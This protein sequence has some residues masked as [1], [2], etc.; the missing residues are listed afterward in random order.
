MP[1]TKKN[2]R[3]YDPQ[4]WLR[5]AVSAQEARAEA[6][7]LTDDQQRD[8]GL[9]YWLCFDQMLHGGSEEAWHSLAS[10]LNIALV[11]VE[12]GFGAEY[13]SE[14]KDAQN[15]LMR[16]KSRQAR[17]GSW[18][19][20]ADGIAAFRKALCIHDAQMG[21]AERSEIRA[22][23]TEVRR[24]IEGGDVLAEVA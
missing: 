22:A 11:L 12:R 14:I 5:R 20:D 18:S 23:T 19:L 24:R 9:S 4:R 15:A 7:P 17:T 21:L 13:E 3:A 8:L 10:T 16:A 1:T 6:A 2:R